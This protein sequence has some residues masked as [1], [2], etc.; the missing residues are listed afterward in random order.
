MLFEL[1]AAQPDREQDRFHESSGIVI[2]GYCVVTVVH[3]DHEGAIIRIDS[4]VDC[5]VRSKTPDDLRPNPQ[6][7]AAEQRKADDPPRWPVKGLEGKPF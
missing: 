7:K 2:D 1:S 4:A 6:I 3:H 5:Q